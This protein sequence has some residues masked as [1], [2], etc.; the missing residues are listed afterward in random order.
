VFTNE[1]WSVRFDPDTRAYEIVSAASGKA[2][3]ADGTKAGSKLS[4]GD[5][6]DSRREF[7]RR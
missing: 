2:L 1:L 7:S 6:T 3:V 4:V 5:A